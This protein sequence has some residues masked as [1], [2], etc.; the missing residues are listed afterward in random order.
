MAQRALGAGM[1]VP[2]K[3]AL[4]GLL[5]AD[6]WGWAGVKAFVWL[7]III[8]LLGYIPDR[9]YYLTVN[10]TV[11][12][13]VVAWSP[14]NL[15]PPGNENL[16]C[17]APVGAL[18]PWH[19]S[20]PEL[21][22][23]TPLTDGAA[24]QL[25]TKILYIG[26]SDGTKA[27]STVYVAQ[28][29]GI[30]NFDK[31]T[32][33]PDLPQPRAD[34]SVVQV[35][36][37][38][39]VIGGFGAD[40]KPTTTIYTLTPDPKTGVLPEWKTAPEQLTLPE[41][42]SGAAGVA[43]PDGLV[44]VGGEGPDGPVAT[45]WHSLFDPQGA[46][47]AWEVEAPLV[48]PQADATASIIGNDIWLYGG[49]DA[50]GP[51]ATVQRGD[52]GLEAAEGYPANPNEGKVVVWGVNPA[53]NLPGPRDDGTG[54][55]ANGSLYLV[56]GKSADGP[57]RETYWAVPNTAGEIPE[58]KHLD[59]SDLPYGVSGGSVIVTGPNAVVIGGAR[60]EGPVA[61]SLRANTAP[62]SPFFQLGLVG[63]TVPGLKID[64][65]IGQQLGYLNAAGAGTVDFVLLLIV[66]WA[67]AHR[68]RAREMVARVIRRRRD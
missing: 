47:Q 59:V 44:L 19:E 26:G 45:T 6:G 43:A 62:Q 53:A 12:L 23:P 4:F 57:Q 7:V 60:A 34:A 32:K 30:G 20:P 1:I 10:R 64:G 14:I 56:G 67:F 28:L 9:A 3:R 31:W 27:Q 35:S 66:G 49:H 24:I 68:E 18:A 48:A 25:G 39:Y 2:R 16:P 22:L 15:C 55:S 65:E 36:G 40:G 42:R 63:A 11:E 29:S 38:V 50:N 58:W 21:A 51:T 17:P 52:L 54:W 5:D 46:L 61:T 8:L 41:A 33:G 13:G 37:T